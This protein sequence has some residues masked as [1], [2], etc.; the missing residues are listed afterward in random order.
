MQSHIEDCKSKRYKTLSKYKA[1]TANVK[2]KEK[3]QKQ[4]GI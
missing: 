2:W 3:Q 1:P 4:A